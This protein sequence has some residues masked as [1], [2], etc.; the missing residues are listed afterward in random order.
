MTHLLRKAAAFI[1]RDF[2]IE[3]SY[4]MSFVMNVVDSMMILDLFLF[5]ERTRRQRRVAVPFPLRRQFSGLHCCWPGF[6]SLF[7]T[8]APDVL[9]VDPHGSAKRL[10]GSDA[11]QSDG[12]LDHRADV[13]ALWVIIRSGA[14]FIDSPCWGASLWVWISV[15]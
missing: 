8:H 2:Q 12:R 1:R 7:P 9:G 11:E 3:S 10:P 4:K 13:I 5:P 14:T 15:I 6:C